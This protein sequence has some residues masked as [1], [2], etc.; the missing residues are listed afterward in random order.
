MAIFFFLDKS[1]S[2]SVFPEKPSNDCTVWYDEF[3]GAICCPFPCWRSIKQELGT[4]VA[5][6]ESTRDC[7]YSTDM[8]VNPVNDIRRFAAA[9]K[10]GNS[11]GPVDALNRIFLYSLKS[12]F[13]CELTVN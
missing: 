8:S 7:C 5:G 1:H 12:L 11:T 9:D 3:T 13:K 6:H 10:S 2:L 4:L